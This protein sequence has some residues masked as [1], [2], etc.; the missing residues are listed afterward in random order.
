MSNGDIVLRGYC[1]GGDIVGGILTGDIDLEPKRP[2]RDSCVHN[3]YQCI[4]AM[5]LSSRNVL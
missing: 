3:V 5:A 2:S 4:N 1:P